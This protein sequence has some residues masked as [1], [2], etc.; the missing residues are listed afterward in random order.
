MRSI[1]SSYSAFYA[2]QCRTLRVNQQRQCFN[3]CQV[4]LREENDNFPRLV[5]SPESGKVRTKNEIGHDEI[6]DFETISFDGNIPYYRP[7][8]P[9][10]FERLPTFQV[11]QLNLHVK[12]LGEFINDVTPLKLVEVSRCFVI[13]Y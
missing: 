2:L 4:E 1:I 10:F 5:A 3:F 6:L 8:K 7:E 9:L 11:R 12:E 13:R